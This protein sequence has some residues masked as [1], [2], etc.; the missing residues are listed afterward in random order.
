MR[1]KTDLVLDI[2]GMIA[3]IFHRY[4]ERIYLQNLKS[5]MMSLL[6][7]ERKS[8]KNYGRGKLKMKNFGLS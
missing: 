2:A 1:K 8:V 3:T 6:S 5:H 4:F 7:L